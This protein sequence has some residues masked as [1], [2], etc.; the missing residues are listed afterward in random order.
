[1][2]EQT[3]DIQTA[4][5]PVWRGSFEDREGHLWRCDIVRRAEVGIRPR[6]MYMSEKPLVIEWEDCAVEEP[7][8]GS[9]ATLTVESQHDRDFTDLYTLYTGAVILKV[10]RDGVLYWQGS[11]DP[12]QYEEPFERLNHYDVTLTFTDF[13]ALSRLRYERP[14]PERSRE[15]LENLLGRSLKK[16]GIIDNEQEVMEQNRGERFAFVSNTEIYGFIPNLDEAG[17]ME[18]EQSDGH[19]EDLT[20]ENLYYNPANFFDEEEEP[21]TYR[22]ALKGILQPLGLKMVQRGG[23]IIIYDLHT[24][25]YGSLSDHNTQ[26]QKGEIY[27]SGDHQTLSVAQTYN[28][29]NITFS[30]YAQSEMYNPDIALKAGSR[31]WNKLYRNAVVYNYDGYTRGTDDYNS[32]RLWLGKQSAEDVFGWHI[33]QVKENS[34]MKQAAFYSVQALQGTASDSTGYALFYDHDG[35]TR[36]IPGGYMAESKI[37]GANGGIVPTAFRSTAIPIPGILDDRARAHRKIR[38]RQPM[39]VD[40][41]YN[42]FETASP[43]AS[44]HLANYETAYKTYTNQ[45][46]TAYLFVAFD[47]ILVADDGKVWQFN[48]IAQAS[49]IKYTI[50]Y[51]Y[52]KPDGNNGVPAV[53]EGSWK[54]YA[55]EE[56]YRAWREANPAHYTGWLEYYGTKITDGI[57]TGFITNRQTIGRLVHADELP[58][59]AKTRPDGLFIPWPP[60]GGRLYYTLYAGL[61]GQPAISQDDYDAY[62]F[63][64]S[65]SQTL[66]GGNTE[67]KGARTG[68]GNHYID[69][70]R[71]CTRWREKTAGNNSTGNNPDRWN[72]GGVYGNLRWWLLQAPEITVS[73]T[74][75]G[76]PKDIELEDIQHLS[77]LNDYADEELSIDT[78][79]GTVP[80]AEPTARGLLYNSYKEPVKVIWRAGMYGYMERCLLGTL[81]SQ[82]SRQRTQLTGEV[83][84]DTRLTESEA[85]P[86]RVDKLAFSEAHYPDK[87]FLMTVESQ[88]I[89]AATA[90]ITI[91]EF[92]PDQYEWEDIGQTGGTDPTGG[93]EGTGF[94][95]TIDDPA[96][97]QNPFDPDD[98]DLPDDIE[99]P[100]DPWD[101][102]YD[103]RDDY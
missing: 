90:D 69:N 39:L 103:D 91:T 97:P 27:W 101:D 89:K 18:E 15:S 24:L 13:G 95:G 43:E 21:L 67:E 46:T 81:Y 45:W 16:A 85:H 73:D 49:A 47:L 37:A 36:I 2:A 82:Y 56:E 12:C 80:D 62:K 44:G 58:E 40:P 65:A 64:L 42:P 99:E 66:P 88:D 60:V 20:P 98:P 9:S 48:N 74:T 52:N 87:V 30:P 31:R 28:R 75:T 100:R 83:R 61:W 1:M 72:G 59:A 84:A 78:I 8:Q 19:F 55:S 41:R 4:M 22:D 51:D 10:Y 92:F 54:C 86:W 93:G 23:K 17:D 6:T 25:Y 94:I 34:T 71:H 79:C 57:P 5:L 7:L 68:N 50:Q 35:R 70:F 14:T 53:G 38:L 63:F 102:Y 76:A 11:L 26:S 32:F 77:S 3:E 29:I 96:D 33:G